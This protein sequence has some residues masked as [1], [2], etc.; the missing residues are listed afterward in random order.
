[1]RQIIMRR[2][3]GRR[4]PLDDENVTAIGAS[5]SPNDDGRRADH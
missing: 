2:C 3:D 1:M 5:S 4:R